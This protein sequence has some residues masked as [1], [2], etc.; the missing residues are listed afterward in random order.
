MSS[1]QEATPVGVQ[2]DGAATLANRVLTAPEHGSGFYFPPT[3]GGF[4]LSLMAFAYSLGLLSIANAD[5][6]NISALGIIVPVA[7]SY[8]AIGLIIGGVWDFRANNLLAAVAGVSYGT[9][10]FSL[11]LLLQFFG[12]DIAKAT[13]GPGF[14]DAVGAYL[15]LWGIFTLLLAAAAYYVA[16]WPFVM[17]IG[18]AAVFIV[19]GIGDMY[20]PGNAADDVRKAGGYVG[21]VDAAMAWYLAAALLVNTT[22][23]RYLLPI[24]PR[25]RTAS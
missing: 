7:F 10:W 16:W 4:T 1:Q 24:F 12:S 5:W 19:L 23:G 14:F 22:T 15:I 3:A 17:L 25:A 21:I 9:F 13:G 20:A 8:G 2:P 6:I 18:L 11:A